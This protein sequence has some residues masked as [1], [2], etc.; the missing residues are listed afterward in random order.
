MAFSWAKYK[1]TS[2]RFKMFRGGEEEWRMNPQ[3]TGL[4][5]LRI[6]PPV[7]SEEEDMSEIWATTEVRRAQIKG[8]RKA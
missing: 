6:C 3:E 7:T 1:T 5:D 2:I 8:M 4:R